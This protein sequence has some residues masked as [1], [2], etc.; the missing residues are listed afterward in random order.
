[1]IPNCRSHCFRLVHHFP[2]DQ[3]D[4]PVTYEYLI[5]SLDNPVLPIRVLAH[6][7]LWEL[8]PKEAASINDPKRKIGYDPAMPTPEMRAPAIRAWQ[9]A[10]PRGKL[11]GAA[12]PPLKK[13][14]NEP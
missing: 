13:P 12:A 6:R 2:I 7:R 14:K 8:A 10:I 3:I 11:P 9:Q 5:E 4:K 1:M